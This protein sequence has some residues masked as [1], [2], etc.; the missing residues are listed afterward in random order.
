MPMSSTASLRRTER[1]APPAS[2][3]PGR[4]ATA[5]AACLL[6]I[7]LVSFRPFQP[8]GGATGDVI[9]CP[10]QAAAG[11]PAVALVNAL[12]PPGIAYGATGQVFLAIEFAL[13]REVLAQLV[14]PL[15][16]RLEH[17]RLV[18]VLLS[19]AETGTLAACIC[20]QVPLFAA[21]LPFQQP[22]G[23]VAVRRVRGDRHRRFRMSCRSRP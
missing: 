17:A 18:P 8:E 15:H 6:T 14:L 20:E 10:L 22:G 9:T 19:Q 5:T 2:L 16:A 4:I 21:V 3:S 1:A 7:V 12:H 13:Q 11:G 23:A